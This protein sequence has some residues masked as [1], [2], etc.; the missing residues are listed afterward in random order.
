MIYIMEY[1]DKTRRYFT[2]T[3]NQAS[4]Q[5]FNEFLLQIFK[6]KFNYIKKTCPKT[7]DTINFFNPDDNNQ[8]IM[9]DSALKQQMANLSGTK[10]INITDRIDSPRLFNDFNM[11]NY[12]L[13]TKYILNINFKFIFDIEINEC[14]KQKKKHTISF[15]KNTYNRKEFT[16][17]KTNYYKSNPK[18]LNHYLKQF[19]GLKLVLLRFTNFFTSSSTKKV[20]IMCEKQFFIDEYII[21]Y[22]FYFL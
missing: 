10:M 4:I 11:D 3:D 19:Y 2:E 22:F 21:H 20:C 14:T 7:E 1:I 16:L 6:T 9:M 13:F 15:N 8:D 17:N 12:S 18:V 5:K